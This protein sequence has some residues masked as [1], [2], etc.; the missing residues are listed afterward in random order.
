[1]CVYIYIY[2]YMYIFVLVYITFLIWDILTFILIGIFKINYSLEVLLEALPP[3]SSNNIH[4][5][6]YI[7][8]YTQARK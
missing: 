2:T 1:M 4:A 5:Y 6:I 8:I 3:V 7:H